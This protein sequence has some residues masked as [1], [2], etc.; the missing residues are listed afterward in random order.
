VRRLVFL[1]TPHRGSFVSERSMVN[2]IARF[3]RLPQT[4]TVAMADL[5]T[6]N[7]D[8]LSFDPRRPVF[9]SIY[10]MRP[11]SRFLVALEETTLAPGVSAHSIIPVQGDLPPD[12]QSDG[13]VQ[14]E[15]AHLDWAESELVIPRSGHS[16][17]RNPLAIEEVRRILV[18][19]A[20]R[21]CQAE[22]VACP[23]SPAPRRAEPEPLPEP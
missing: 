10:T 15:S 13:V 19:H 5:V 20:D 1:A 18:E 2:L 9:S 14:F 21:V 17:Q 12:G 6:G 8:A 3:I 23:P 11:G 22:G 4:V 7:A 16:V